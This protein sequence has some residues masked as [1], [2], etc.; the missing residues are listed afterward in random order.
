MREM[1][2]ASGEAAR[3]WASRISQ[4]RAC[5][6]AKASDKSGSTEFPAIA[7]LATVLLVEKIQ[8]QNNSQNCLSLTGL[9]KF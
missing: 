8:P 2:D 6:Q 9:H 4:T 5:S 3:A 7:S 1:R